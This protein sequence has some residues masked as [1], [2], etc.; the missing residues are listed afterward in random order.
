MSTLSVLFGRFRKGIVDGIAEIFHEAFDFGVRHWF[1]QDFQFPMVLIVPLQSA[2]CNCA[3]PWQAKKKIAASGKSGR[4][5]SHDSH[6]APCHGAP[7][8]GGQK[9]SVPVPGL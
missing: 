3:M 1:L 5:R 9:E 7:Y 2:I 6:G 4:V 8:M